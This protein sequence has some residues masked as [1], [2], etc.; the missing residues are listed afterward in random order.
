MKIIDITRTIQ[1]APIYPGSEPFSISALTT[2]GAKEQ[3]NITILHGDSHL[4]THID[5]PRHALADG[6]SIAHTDLSLYY[7]PC[8][9]VSVP[10]K[11]ILTVSHLQPYLRN[12][13]RLLLKSNG[14]S[15]LS[16]ETALFLTKQKLVLLGT[17]GLSPAPQNNEGPIHRILLR[18]NIALLENLLLEHVPDGDYLL[19]AFP[20]KFEN[21]D[22]SPVRAVLLAD[23]SSDL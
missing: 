22:G 4:G 14:T 1:E 8:R 7:G 13:S 23:H 9:V 3:F 19:C 2:I 18:E 16:E 6:A 12:C 15:Y 5:A 11:I 21:G 17:D 10:E 20:L